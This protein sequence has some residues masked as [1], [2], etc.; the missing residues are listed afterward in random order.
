MKPLSLAVLG[1]S[2][3][4]ASCAA[5]PLDPY[6]IEAIERIVQKQLAKERNVGF[7]VGVIEG[8]RISV[9]GFGRVS[10][11]SD[12]K[13][14]GA[15]IYEIGSITKV[16]TTCLLADLARDGVV[17]LNDPISRHLPQGVRAP[18]SDNN[19]IT[20][21]HLATHTSGLP[22][23]PQNLAPIEADPYASYDTEKLYA[24]LSDHRLQ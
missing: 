4:L 16:F 21:N 7:A 13:P 12:A 22:R 1:L 24:F 8:N 3:A 6:R 11:D 23:L 19:E 9:L 5:Q 18:R 15:T 2:A 10:K 14:T 20:L 17:A